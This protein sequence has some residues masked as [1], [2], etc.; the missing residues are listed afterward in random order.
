MLLRTADGS[1]RIDMKKVL[2]ILAAALCLLTSCGKDKPVADP[3]V[4]DWHC[5]AGAFKAEIYV[6][7]TAEKTFV[8]YQQIGEG[9]Y[10]VFNGT[11]QLTNAEDGI[12]RILTGMYNDGNP[13][14]TEYKMVMSSDTAMTLTA[15]GVSE[16]YEK[17]S[18]GIPAEVIAS[19]VTVVKSEGQTEVPFL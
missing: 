5:S 8:L 18:D 16:S 4:G 13:W 7:F 6:T 1:K 19:S 15:E 2:Y 12:G 14:A 17:L 11:Y 3:I 10:R 9:A